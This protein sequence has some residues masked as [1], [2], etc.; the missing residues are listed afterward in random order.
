[1]GRDAERE[2]NVGMEENGG[3]KEVQRITGAPFSGI[4]DAC[5]STLF[6]GSF[7]RH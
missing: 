5:R 6:P 4:L 1:V 2:K 7:T 3:E